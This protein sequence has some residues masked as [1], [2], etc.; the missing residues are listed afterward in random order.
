[1]ENCFSHHA[2]LSGF[3]FP[4]ILTPIDICALTFALEMRLTSDR[5]K[6]LSISFIADYAHLNL[7]AAPPAHSPLVV[8]CS[9]I[10]NLLSRR[11]MKGN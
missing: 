5:R 8:G 10:V 6:G 11:K 1:L 3:L 9:L 4:D 7:H 2:L